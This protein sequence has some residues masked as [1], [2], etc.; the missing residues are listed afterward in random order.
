MWGTSQKIG[1]KTDPATECGVTNAGM[2]V[3]RSFHL[4]CQDDEVKVEDDEL[5]YEG[6]NTVT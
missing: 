2:N 4:W 5:G 6:D 1:E 3:T